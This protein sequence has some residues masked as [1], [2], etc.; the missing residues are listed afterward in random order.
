M[1][2]SYLYP[3]DYIHISLNYLRRMKGVDAYVFLIEN[4]FSIIESGYLE[5]NN[6]DFDCSHYY[7]QI[8]RNNAQPSQKIKMII[9]LQYCESTRWDD[10]GYDQVSWQKDLHFE[11]VIYD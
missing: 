6:P 8:F 7:F 3:N 1:L 4:N 10:A 2:E 11:E 5:N 9:F